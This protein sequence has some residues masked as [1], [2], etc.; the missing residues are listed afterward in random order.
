MKVTALNTDGYQY[1]KDCR[2]ARGLAYICRPLIY[3]LLKLCPSMSVVANVDI[4]GKFD[5]AIRIDRS[6]NTKIYNVTFDGSR[7]E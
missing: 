2:F 6:S 1:N 5:C 7:D 4:T 3:A